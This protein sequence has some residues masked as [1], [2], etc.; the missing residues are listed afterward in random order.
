MTDEDDYKTVKEVAKIFKVSNR[1]VYEK[2]KASIWPHWKAGRQIR[3]SPEDVEQI[4]QIGKPQ[5][6][7]SK[8]RIRDHYSNRK[9]FTA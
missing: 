6:A 7:R 3:F 8:G 4:K 1:T 9:G 5:P 2:V